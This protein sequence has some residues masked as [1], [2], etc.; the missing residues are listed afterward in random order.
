MKSWP[1]VKHFVIFCEIIY[2]GE[3]CEIWDREELGLRFNLLEF[4]VQSSIKHIFIPLMIQ[5]VDISSFREQ[6]VLSGRTSMDDNC[7][8]F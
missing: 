2:V 5:F 8:G 3:T 6:S 7:W 1:E 4:T